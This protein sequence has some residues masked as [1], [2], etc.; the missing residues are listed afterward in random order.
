MLNIVERRIRL[1]R[2]SQFFVNIHFDKAFVYTSPGCLGSHTFQQM[3]FLTTKMELLLAVA[4]IFLCAVICVYWIMSLFQKKP[5]LMLH[6]SGTEC[7]QSRC[8]SYYS[9]FL[10][11]KGEMCEIA[12]TILAPHPRIKNWDANWRKQ[13]FEVTNRTLL[14]MFQLVC[15]AEYNTADCTSWKVGSLL[16]H[17][18][19]RMLFS[20]EWT[21][22]G[23]NSSFA[24]AMNDFCDHY[25][26]HIK[27]S[28]G[29]TT[30]AL[31]GD[32][33]VG[34]P[35]RDPVAVVNKQ[36]EVKL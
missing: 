25:V 34:T 15:L 10:Q 5:I 33:M 36:G 8:Q 4:I 6:R 3:N 13:Q 29:T 7:K 19:D 20:L 24:Q 11:N 21:P 2:V 1:N 16:V 23:K 26:L 32:N 22:G 18:A 30:L 28:C 27:H 35:S 9:V 12:E 14:Q 31:N 17:D